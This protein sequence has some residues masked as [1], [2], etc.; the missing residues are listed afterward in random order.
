MYLPQDFHCAKSFKKTLATLK[1]AF[2]DSAVFEDRTIDAPLL[3]LGLTFRE[4]SRAMEI[5]EIEEIEAGEPSKFPL[6]LVQSP[7]GIRELQKMEELL[8]S[9]S[10]P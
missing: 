4:I 7:L 1:K 2:T 3:F 6:H 9:I 10:L 5:E 8:E